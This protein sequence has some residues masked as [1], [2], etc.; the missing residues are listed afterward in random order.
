MCDQ[1]LGQNAN[2]NTTSASIKVAIMGLND[3]KVGRVLGH[4]PAGHEAGK[5]Q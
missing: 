4:K 1:R 2:M 5:E 3:A